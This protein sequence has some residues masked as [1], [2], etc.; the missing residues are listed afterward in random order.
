M[1]SFLFWPIIAG[2]GPGV[3]MIARWHLS[4]DNWF[5]FYQQVSIAIIFLVRVGLHICFPFSVFWF[6]LVWILFVQSLCMLSQSLL[7]LLCFNTVVYASVKFPIP[8]ITL[9]LFSREAIF[10]DKHIHYEGI[11]LFMVIFD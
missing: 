7:V 11:K 8:M 9:V 4:V 10:P 2:H 6:C 5:P 3:K 1:E